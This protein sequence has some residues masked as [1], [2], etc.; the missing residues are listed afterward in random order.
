M[1]INWIAI[2]V[3][4][5][6]KK[7][8]FPKLALICVYCHVKMVGFSFFVFILFHH[9]SHQDISACYFAYIQLYRYSTETCFSHP[10]HQHLF[11]KPVSIIFF[12]Q[13]VFFLL[14]DPLLQFS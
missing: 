3:L 5:D 6:L 9:L 13:L 11:N 10:L 4:H 8:I 7:K 2:Q 14:I 1:H 12:L